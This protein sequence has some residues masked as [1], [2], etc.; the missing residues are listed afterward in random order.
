ML[1]ELYNVNLEPRDLL[2]S[3]L[4]FD[5]CVPAVSPSC[6][7]A[8]VCLD[9]LFDDVVRDFR[10]SSV[11]LVE[12]QLRFILIREIHVFVISFPNHPPSVNR[13]VVTKVSMPLKY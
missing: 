2:V 12:Y 11:E 7:D 3:C 9:A 6:V 10:G 5:A 1:N 13:A 4:V 8:V